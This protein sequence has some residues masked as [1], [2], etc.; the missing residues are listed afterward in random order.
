MRELAPMYMCSC[1]GLTDSDVQ[2]VGRVGIIQPDTLID[3]L[4]LDDELCCGRCA[5]EIDSFVAVAEEEWAHA[6]MALQDVPLSQLAA[7]H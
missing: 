7:L 4:G 2:A 1:R 5:L 6:Q 3:V